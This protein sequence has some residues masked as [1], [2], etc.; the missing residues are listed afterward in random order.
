MVCGEDDDGSVPTA[1]TEEN[2]RSAPKDKV[3]TQYSKKCPA[4]AGSRLALQLI[5]VKRSTNESS[6][7]HG[8]DA[9]VLFFLV[10]TSL[11]QD[12]VNCASTDFGRISRVKNCNSLTA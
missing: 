5:P 8:T 2:N 12:Q 1:Y 9:R 4:V 7:S 6:Q 11:C 3:Q 10:T